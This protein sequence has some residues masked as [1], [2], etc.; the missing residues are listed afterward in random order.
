MLSLRL[1]T[2][3]PVVLLISSALA[4][5]MPAV[6]RQDATTCGS[7]SY[8]VKQVTAALNAGYSYYSDNDEA[9]SSDY[10]H[11]YND[12]EG[13]DFPV[14]GPYQEFPILS[15]GKVYSGGS[16]GADRVI[17]NTDGEYAGSITHTGASGDDFVGCS[18]V[19][20]PSK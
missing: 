15:S 1:P 11:K 9:G 17:F 19:T 5:P 3:L 6:K 16:P 20:D 7:H 4:T 12:Y 13:F 2:L 10:P 18:D 14:D 8:T